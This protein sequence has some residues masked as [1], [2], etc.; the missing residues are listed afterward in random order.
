MSQSKYA[1]MQK[2]L[3]ETEA[4]KWSLETKDPVVG[5]FEL[6]NLWPDYDIYLFKDIETAG[7]TALDF[8]C[9]PGR[10]IV[11]FADRF[12]QIDGVDISQTNLN[13]A[14]IWF[15]KNNLQ[16]IPQLFVNN[17]I[18]LTG[19]NDNVYDVVFSTIAMQH[20][21]VHETRYSL[22]SEFYRVLKPGGSLCIQMGYGASP[23][24]RAVH[25]HDNYYDA[26]GTNGFCDVRIDDSDQLKND[27]DQIGFTNFQ[28]DIRPV[29][30]GDG[31][32]N[33]I[34]FRGIK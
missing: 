7:K 6:H 12:S 18:D 22:L 9:G 21:C 27:L 19:I 4:V 10:N 33:W 13:K 16:T 5:S 3:Y 31:H 23:H 1:Q 8:G 26:E 17:G 25:Y 2:E 28:Y 15:M 14:R 30:P 32:A 24:K 29:G 34:F 11:K 20:I